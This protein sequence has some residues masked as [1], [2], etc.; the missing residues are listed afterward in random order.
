M[1]RASLAVALGLLMLVGCGVTTSQPP[2]EVF[3]DMRRQPKYKALG[4][5][6]FFSDGRASRPPVPGTVAAGRLIGDEA[7]ETGIAGKMYVGR[8]PLPIDAALLARGRERFDIYCSICHDRAGDG[9]GIVPVRTAW[10]AVNL[11]D[12]RILQMTDGELFNVATY[13]RRTMP[14][15][16]FQIPPADRWAI[17]AYVRALQ[18]AGQGA[19]E[20][21]PSEVRGQVR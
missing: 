17:V 3:S 21:V 15:Y 10:L 18:R 16:R 20:D 6:P 19:I 8:N 12:E 7:F 14:A 9:K 4:A 13:G 1:K 2:V 5:S 11:H